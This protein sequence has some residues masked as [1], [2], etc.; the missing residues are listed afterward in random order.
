MKAK[1]ENPERKSGV[2]P[3]RRLEGV[4]RPLPAAP[5]TEMIPDVLACLSSGHYHLGRE[6]DRDA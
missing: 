2:G 3:H 1:G 4:L 6:G 5:A